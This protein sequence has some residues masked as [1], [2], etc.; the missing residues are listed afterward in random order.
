M[1][2][3]SGKTTDSLVKTLCDHPHKFDFFQ[4]LRA[5]QNYYKDAPR[6][7]EAKRAKDDPFRFSQKISLNFTTSMI[8]SVEMDEEERRLH[9]TV[10]FLGLL[11]PNG[12]MP[13]HLTEHITHRILHGHDTTLSSFLNIFQHRLISLFFKAWA[14]N[15]QTVDFDLQ[16]NS[17]YVVYLGSLFGFGLKSLQNRDSIPDFSK[18][19]YANRLVQKTCNVEGLKSIIGDY[20]GVPSSINEF[21]GQWLDLPS[22]SRCYLGKSRATG[23]LGLNT[24]VGTKVWDCQLKFRIRMGPMGRKDLNRMLPGEKTFKRIRD[25]VLAY[26]GYEYFWD[27]QLVLKREEVPELQLGREARLGW[28]SYL[29]TK[30]FKR[31]ADDLILDSDLYQGLTPSP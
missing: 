13:L 5:L 3:E 11:G 28:N 15:N 1:A 8:D 31:D 21:C 17:R 23:T 19:Y 26:V 12:P 2:G 7:G 20:F 10:S 22:D 14:L 6:I 4:A 27:L 29:K 24:I 18:L 25:W 9:M 16:E 30:P